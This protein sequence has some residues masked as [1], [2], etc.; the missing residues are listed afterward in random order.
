MKKTFFLILAVA[1]IVGAVAWINLRKEPDNPNL[2]KGNGRIEAT[3]IDLATKI[4]GRLEEMLVNEGDFVT[5]GQ[6]LAKIHS[7]SLEAELAENRA[8]HAEAINEVA[9]AEAQVTS[10]RSDKVAAEAVVTQ[11]ESESTAARQRVERSEGLS[12][13]GAV[14]KQTLDDDRA[15]AESAAA[16]VAA[17][18]AQVTASDAAILAAQAQVSRAESAVSAA[19]AAIARI[20]SDID[21]CTLR[22]PRDGRVQYRIA[23]VGE[24][25]G[26]GG[27]VLNIV[28]LADVYMTFFIPETVAGRIA[29]GSEVRLVLDAVPDHVIPAKVSYV[30]SVAQFT[31]KTV[32][33]ESERQKLMFRVKG[34]LDP[35]LLRK[36]IKQVKTG[37]PGVAYLNI[38]EA[39]EWPDNL[40][41]TTPQ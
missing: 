10:R 16:G 32:E 40:S 27:K 34:Q 25:L 19:E 3:E 36:H 31:P 1:C 4:S 21:E 29:L 17:A 20:Q 30:A 8:R 15:A 28:D 18:R 11:R 37:L 35:A 13:G 41:I 24:V 7:A 2:V 14:A 12:Q 33:T 23:Q 22:A 5:A 9:S 39:S 38:G 26:V 6:V